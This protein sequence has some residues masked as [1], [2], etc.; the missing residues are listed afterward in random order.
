[1]VGVGRVG[2][3]ISLVSSTDMSISFLCITEIKESEL[4]DTEMFKVFMLFISLYKKGNFEWK[5]MTD[6]GAHMFNSFTPL[7][8]SRKDM[9]PVEICSEVFNIRD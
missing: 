7:Y 1:M 4:P 2:Y 9:I 5:I 3:I 8:R 6:S